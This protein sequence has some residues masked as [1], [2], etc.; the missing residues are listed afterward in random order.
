MSNR[1]KIFTVAGVI[2]T[3]QIFY[4][5]DYLLP[6]HWGQIKV[7][8]MACTCPDEKVVNGSLYLKSITPDSLAKFDLSYS[9]IYVTKALTSTLDPMGTDLYMIEGQIIGK[10]RVSPTDPW[11]PVVLVTNWREV[12]LL[13]DWAVKALFGLQLFLLMVITSKSVLKE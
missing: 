10:N 8:G 6:I 1:L 7:S 4:F 9:E 3:A 13:K 12:D 11:H 5:S 2:L